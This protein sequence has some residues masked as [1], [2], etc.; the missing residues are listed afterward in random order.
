MPS[1]GPTRPASVPKPKQGELSDKQER[2][3]RKYL[4]DLNVTQAAIRAG[5]SRKTANE[6]GSQNL[7]KLSVSQAIAERQAERARRLDL[8]TDDV[9]DELRK[10][11]F[12]SMRHYLRRTEYFILDADTTE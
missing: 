2:F 1:R 12:S 6:Q 3:V 8:K 9:V 5:Y 7:V 11:A 10:V 4:V